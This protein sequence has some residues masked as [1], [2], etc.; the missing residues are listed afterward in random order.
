MRK[1]GKLPAA[2]RASARCRLGR[3]GPCGAGLARCRLGWTG[4]GRDDRVGGAAFR[5]TGRRGFRGLLSHV[6]HLK[7]IG[8]PGKPGQRSQKPGVQA[9]LTGRE[10]G[11]AGGPLRTATTAESLQVTLR[12]PS[13]L[14]ASYFLRSNGVQVNRFFPGPNPGIGFHRDAEAMRAISSR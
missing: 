2:G 13:R 1:V 14:L 12:V 9:D 5:R 10:L 11:A 3:R 8:G 6:L 7:S 4:P